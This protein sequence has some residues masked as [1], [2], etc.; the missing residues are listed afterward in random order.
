[1]KIFKNA[2]IDIVQHML[3]YDNRII[4]NGKIGKGPKCAICLL[5]VAK[6]QKVYYKSF[7]LII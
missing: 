7:F 5:D 3:S 1:M 6:F 2:Q 4:K